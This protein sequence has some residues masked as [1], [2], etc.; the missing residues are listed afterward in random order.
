MTNAS[1]RL[2][3]LAATAVLAVPAAGAAQTVQGSLVQDEDGAPIAGAEVVLL[4]Q[5]ANEVTRTTTDAGGAFVLTAPAAGVFMVMV[6]RE[7]FANHLT[8]AFAIGENEAYPLNL[9]LRSQRIGDTG[10][11]ADTLDDAALLAAAIA[12][13]CSA[14]FIPT[15]HGIL[16]GAIRDEATGEP[17]PGAAAH[18]DW[19]VTGLAGAGSANDVVRADGS[20]AYLLC[21]VPAGT[22]VEIH[23]SLSSVSGDGETVEVRAGMMRKMDL[24]IPLSDPSQPGN[25]L[26]RVIDF[27]SG[28]PL[29]GASVSLRS[30]QRSVVTNARGVFI[31]RSVPSGPDSLLVENLGYATQKM[32]VQVVGGRAQELEV[33]LDKDPVELAPILVSVQPRRWFSDRAGLEERIDLGNGLILTED[34][35]IERA[36]TVLGDALRGLPGVQVTKSGGGLSGTWTVQLRGAANLSGQACQPMVWVDG[37]RWGADGSA[38][39]ELGGHEL[40]AV[41]IY[42]GPAEVPG[43]FS[44]GD[45]RCGVIVVWTRRGR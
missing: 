3:I 38:F 20:G 8:D 36:P 7:G 9:T 12:S 44:G 24:F 26:G 6:E 18:I 42:R 32:S 22:D 15:L 14:Q 27:R 30:S 25:L 2:L 21:T 31:L 16:F 39:R 34:D 41:E 23:A 28:Q 35:L 19:R 17:L 29:A 33:R 10:V 37:V 45:A 43:E 40:H 4:D 1:C 5:G 11:V 13:A